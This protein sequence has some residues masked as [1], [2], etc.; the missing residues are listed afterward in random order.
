MFTW[1]C[2]SA[3]RLMCVEVRGQLCD[4]SYFLRWSLTESG[5]HPFDGLASKHRGLPISASPVL[6]S[7][8]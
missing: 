1:V 3:C 6:E 4:H 2:L 5:A 8:T 7:Q